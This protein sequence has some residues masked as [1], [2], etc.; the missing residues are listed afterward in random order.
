MQQ[1]GMKG[2]MYVLVVVLHVLGSHQLGRWVDVSFAEK[3]EKVMERLQSL[4]TEDS[5]VQTGLTTST[6]RS[7]MSVCFP[8]L[9]ISCLFSCVVGLLP[10]ELCLFACKVLLQKGL[11]FL[12]PPGLH[13]A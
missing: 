3:I 7:P 11:G 1:E 6:T 2:C 12:F 5:Y 10:V 4:E 8:I 9:L 13:K